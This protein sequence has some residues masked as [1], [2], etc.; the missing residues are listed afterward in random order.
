[1]PHIKTF[2]SNGSRFHTITAGQDN[3]G[4]HRTITTTRV[5]MWLEQRKWVNRVGLKTL[6]FAAVSN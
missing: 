3:T 4:L 2:L 6:K 1:M 5:T